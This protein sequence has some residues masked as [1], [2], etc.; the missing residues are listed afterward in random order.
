MINILILK[1]KKIKKRSA[2]LRHLWPSKNPCLVSC[3]DLVS[4]GQ[5]I[6]E[7]YF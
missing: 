2:G 5:W 1:K 7:S 4:E 6:P 3:K